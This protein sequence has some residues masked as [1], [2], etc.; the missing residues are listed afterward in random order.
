MPLASYSFP[1]S[2]CGRPVAKGEAMVRSRCG[3]LWVHAVCSPVPA[4]GQIIRLPDVII[5]TTLVPYGAPVPRK[6]VTPQIPPLAGMA[7]LGAA[8]IPQPSSSSGVASVLAIRP[9][10]PR[11]P[12]VNPAKSG[13]VAGWS[14]AIPLGKPRAAAVAAPSNVPAY[15]ARLRK[16]YGLSAEWLPHH[17]ACGY[18]ETPASASS[19]AQQGE[20]WAAGDAKAAAK[21][22][23]LAAQRGPCTPA[24]VECSHGHC[25]KCAG[26]VPDQ[27]AKA[28]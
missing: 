20:R 11:K 8:P 9:K 15:V 26:C 3:S 21:R 16:R 1:C 23:A 24:T 6:P 7:P 28:A 17:V 4:T 18:P 25:G 22:N 2:S 10:A 12:R 14:I 19:A 13:D 5:E 27:I